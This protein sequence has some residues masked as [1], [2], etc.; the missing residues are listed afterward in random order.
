M[1]SLL[2]FAVILA[3]VP[4][5]PQ[6]KYTPT[7]VKDWEAKSDN[8][9]A[10]Y[11]LTFVDLM[12]PSAAPSYKV[13]PGQIRD[14]FL[15]RTPADKMPEGIAM[16]IAGTGLLDRAAKRGGIDLSKIYIE[17]VVQWVTDLKFTAGLSPLS[18]AP[19]RAVQESAKPAAKKKVPDI[20]PNDDP[21]GQGGFITP[22]RP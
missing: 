20:D 5:L 13:K 15:H 2:L 3:A 11:V 19:F 14:Y 16:V 7:S 9:Q 4:A 10:A 6:G 1:K 21:I 18:Q 17:D 12:A 8:L 22:H